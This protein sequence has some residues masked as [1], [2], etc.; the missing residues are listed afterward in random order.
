MKL[1]IFPLYRIKN[2]S[3]IDNNLSRLLLKSTTLT[4]D[5]N[6][7]TGFKEIEVV[8]IQE[9]IDKKY[10]YLTEACEKTIVD[11]NLLIDTIKTKL[12]DVIY[13][14][15]KQPCQKIIFMSAG[16]D[17]RILAWLIKDL[18]NKYGSFLTDDIMFICHHPEGEL[19]EAAMEQMGWE[20]G[21]YHVHRKS[22]QQSADY[23][24]YGD[25]TLNMNSFDYPAINFWSDIVPRGTEKNFIV[26]SG[27]YGGEL[28]S[29]PLYKPHGLLTNRYEILHKWV[30]EYNIR[31]AFMNIL[32]KDVCMPFL[33]YNYLDTIFRIDKSLYSYYNNQVGYYAIDRIRG[34]LLKSFNDNV[35]CYVGHNYDFTMSP[36]LQRH[37]QYNWKNSKLIR[38]FGDDAILLEGENIKIKDFT[39]GLK[40]R[41]CVDSKLYSL[42]TVYEYLY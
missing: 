16:A 33:D 39:P 4:I 2:T 28:L 32:W 3:E 30:G 25:F 10:L 15:L 11:F 5:V 12:S 38:D 20:K 18:E 24:S 27:A 17:S 29:Y 36:E 40:I 35:K 22:M 34:E 6:S 26:L 41:G 31:S 13:E 9:N 42:A 19:F 21:K 23:Y 37:I 1:P 7:I 14:F 8:P